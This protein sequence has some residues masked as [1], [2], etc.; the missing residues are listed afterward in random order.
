MCNILLRVTDSFVDDSR[1]SGRGG[2]E[3]EEGGEKLYH[4]K[5]MYVITH[6]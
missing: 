4:F 3:E 2:G 6:I 1:L 5:L